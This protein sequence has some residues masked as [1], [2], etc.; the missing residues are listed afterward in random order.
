MLNPAT[1]LQLVYESL[2]KLT[3]ERDVLNKQLEDQDAV[4]YD[5]EVAKQEVESLSKEV[6][7]IVGY[8]SRAQELEAEI[9]ELA[10]KQKAAGL[11][12]GIDAI[13]ADLKRVSEDSRNAR[14]TLEQLTA[15]RDKSRN[16]ITTLELSVRDVN[17]DLNSAQSKLKEKRALADRVEDFKK[18]NNKQREA[19]RSFD[20]Q[21]SSIDPEI[22][23]AQYKY[24]DINR[25]GNDRV[26]RAHDEASRLSDSVRQLNQANEEID[27]YVNRGGPQ[28]LARTHREIE[29]LQGEIARI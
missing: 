10:Q 23:Q 6:Q 25:R 27:S 20:E 5:L 19:I 22:E 28:Q 11:S 9:K 4:I 1:N 16:L 8:Y 2:T 13:Q 3:A 17:A 7:T 29:N 21:I 14:T 18:E 24:D 26:Q 15:A 12:R